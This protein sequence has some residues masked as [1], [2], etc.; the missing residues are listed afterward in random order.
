MVNKSAADCSFIGN[1]P[2]ID[3]D[4]Q[5][6][7]TTYRRRSRCACHPH[8]RADPLS[9]ATLIVNCNASL[10]EHSPATSQVRRIN[11]LLGACGR[12]S[13]I[14]R[15]EEFGTEPLRPHGDGAG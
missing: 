11:G 13:V 10:H 5:L 8:G 6:R 1:K 9:Y 12:L 14:R 7:P 2:S 15:A 4:G 3:W